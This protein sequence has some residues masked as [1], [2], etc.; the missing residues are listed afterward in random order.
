MNEIDKN[1]IINE[2]VSELMSCHKIDSFYQSLV[3][4]KGLDIKCIFSFWRS[5]LLL[6]WLFF[7]LF[8]NFSLLTNENLFLTFL[9]EILAV[10]SGISI[11]NTTSVFLNCQKVKGSIKRMIKPLLI[12]KSLAYFKSNPEMYNDQ[13]FKDFV[14]Y[15][16]N[17]YSSYDHEKE[18][19]NNF[20]KDIEKNIYDKIYSSYDVS[21]KNDISIKKIKVQDSLIKE[22]EK[23][24]LG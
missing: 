21:E 16:K 4:N 11:L 8:F 15:E 22:L 2:S 13:I 10:F 9:A 5:L 20:F 7:S 1:G 6:F 24:Y 17:N 3:G 18:T 19:Y 14:D 23:K 12:K